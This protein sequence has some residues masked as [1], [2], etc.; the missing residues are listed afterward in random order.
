MMSDQSLLVTPVPRSL[1]TKNKILGLDLVDVL[2]LLIN[3]SVQNLLFGSTFL[4]IPMVFG[5]SLILGFTLFFVK[6]GKPDNY[7]QHSLEYWVLPQVFYA[8]MKDQKNGGG[9]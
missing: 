3:L 9:I 8:Y 2:F 4:K 1:E 5:T 6:K 7:L